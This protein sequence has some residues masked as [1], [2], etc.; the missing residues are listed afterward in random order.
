M[1]N[2]RD[3]WLKEVPEFAAAYKG[4]RPKESTAPPQPKRA[5]GGAKRNELTDKFL[6]YWKLCT[7][8]PQPVREHRFHETRRWRFDLAWPALKLAAE[9]HGGVWIR[10]GHSRGK[11]QQKDFDKLNA[12]I[13]L[14]WT[15]LQFGTD[16]VSQKQ[17][18]DT[19]RTVR[20][21]IE[22]RTGER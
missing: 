17:I 13:A 1:S 18:A 20:E 9:F 10:G 4:P 15:V 19:L 5:K 3:I 22:Q 12:A 7:F 16:A 8:L 11:G 2:N 21:A 14:G 6:G